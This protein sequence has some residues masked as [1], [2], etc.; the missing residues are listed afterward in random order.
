M[1]IEL[2]TIVVDDYDRAIGFFTGVLGFALAEDSPART[3]DGRPKRWVVVRPPGGGT[4]ILLARADGERQAAAVGDQVAGR[5]G[6]FLRVADFAAE[7]ARL[8]DAGVEFVTAPRTEPY[9]RVAV[10]LDIAG[11]RWDLLGPA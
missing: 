5:V 9:G 8:V 1:R 2:V 10:F 7:Y 3:N 6:F 11:N 4:G